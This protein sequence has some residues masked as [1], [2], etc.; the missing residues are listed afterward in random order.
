MNKKEMRKITNALYKN[1]KLKPPKELVVLNG[2]HEFA[3]LYMMLAAAPEWH[4]RLEQQGHEIFGNI[5]RNLL[6]TKTVDTIEQIDRL[7]W[8]FVTSPPKYEELEKMQVD[9]IEQYPKLWLRQTSRYINEMIRSNTMK[10]IHYSTYS[11]GD[12]HSTRK[13]N[14]RAFT[15]LMKSKY[16]ATFLTDI[17]IWHKL[18]EID[19]IEIEDRHR[20]F[21]FHNVDGPA[22]RFHDG[23][24]FYFINGMRVTKTQHKRANMKPNR[25]QPNS[26]LNTRN[27]EVR[28]LLLERMGGNEALLKK[29]RESK[30]YKV[31]KIN[32]SKFG[33][34]YHIVHVNN[35]SKYYLGQ[36]TEAMLQTEHKYKTTKN[37][38]PVK[39]THK[40]K[41]SEMWRI[42]ANMMDRAFLV[43]TDATPE[44]DGTYPEY[45]LMTRT[46]YKT[47]KEAVAESF[48]MREKDYNP[49]IQT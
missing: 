42:W 40:E 48:G 46:A 47:A 2:L 44:S 18:P 6:P 38:A 1:A 13:R 10:M 39:V 35:Y 16:A 15:D 27:T 33:T 22:V 32:S 8:D 30:H 20:S 31:F 34:L 9:L 29:I 4:G 11:A 24:E 36:L 23:R 21:G 43:V 7:T 41:L 45:V 25:I 14:P 5:S 26:I 37:G 3:A 17:A 28:R 19:V 12:I 49:Q